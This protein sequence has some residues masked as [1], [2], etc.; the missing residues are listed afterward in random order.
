[1]I[2]PMRRFRAGSGAPWE[3]RVGYARVVRVGAHVHVTGTTATRPDGSPFEGDAYEQTQQIVRNLERA[4][5]RVGARLDEVV[6]TRIFVTDIAADWEDVGRAHAEAFGALR[7]ATSMVEVAALIAPWMRVEIEADA[8]LGAA[9]PLDAPE[10]YVRNERP[11][12]RES[13]IAMA[14]AEG[15][16]V[17]G[18]EVSF[19]VATELD[20]ALVAAAG[21]ERHGDAGILR[22][23]VTRPSA[24][25]GGVATLLVDTLLCRHGDLDLWLATRDRAAFF[26]RF[27]FRPVDRALVPAALAATETFVHAACAD[28]TVMRRRLA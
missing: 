18:P 11:D 7:P 28:A 14:Q 27:G 12:D 2:A 1:M 26:S 13:L 15:L 9:P 21:L 4:L 10:V 22:S 23:V 6:R 20:G 25:G 17:P 5:A 3:T 19:L 16:P 24:R 8:L